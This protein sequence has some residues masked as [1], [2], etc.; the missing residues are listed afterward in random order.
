MNVNSASDPGS[1]TE[2]SKSRRLPC[3]ITGKEYPRRD[4]VALDALR[5]SLADR[6]RR[7]YPELTYDALISKAELGQYR[8]KYVEELLKAEHGDLT[9][10]DR[11]RPE[12][13]G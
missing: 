6:I 12:V 9:E 2:K 8:T 5:P 4:L 10:L 13:F 7:D 3:A 1:A 11:R